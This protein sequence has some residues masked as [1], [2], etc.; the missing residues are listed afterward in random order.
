[1]NRAFPFLILL[2]CTG[3]A[4]KSEAT[5]ELRVLSNN[6]KHGH[7]MDGKVDISRAADLIN[8]LK[9]DLVVLQ[10][11]DNG[12]ERSGRQDQMAVLSD[13][14][15][16]HARFGPFMPYQ[17][18]HYGIGLMSRF[19][20]LESKN[21][22][23]PEGAEP[24]SALEARVQLPNAEELLLCS[25]HLYRS[26][27]E[28]LAQARA[29]VTLSE[30]LETPMILG[31]TSTRHPAPARMAV[32]RG[33]NETPVMH[34]TLTTLFL[35]TLLCSFSAIGQ[36]QSIH[37]PAEVPFPKGM[38]TGGDF[39]FRMCVRM[40]SPPDDLPTLAANKAWEEG[41]IKDYTTNNTYGV[42][43]ESG[44]QAGFA[45]SVL[46]DGAW[47]WNAGDGRRRIDHRPEARD[48]G[49]ADGRWH[50]L[51]FAIDREH[52][53]AHLYHDGRRVAVHDLQGVGSLA[54]KAAS[55]AVGSSNHRFE[56]GAVRLEPGVLPRSSFA[57]DFA[58]RFGEARRPARVAR[59]DGRPLRVLAWNIWHGGR[60]KGRDEG[61]Q[62][63]VDVIRGCK[64]DIVL[65]QET[66]G[67]GPRIS[68]RLGFD[69]FLRSANLSVMSRFPIVGVH[70]LG[71]GFRFG[72]VTIEL[73]PK[74]RV[75]AYSLWINYL[76]GVAKQ[77]AAGAS[78]EELVAADARTRGKEMD[79]ILR[80]LLPYLARS[81]NM[82]VVV[83]GDFNSGS[84]LDWTATTAHLPNHHGLVVP[85]PASR[86]MAKAGFVDA[87]R[88]ANPDP[89]KA[90][91]HTWSPEF[92]DSHQER[93]D[94]VY[95]RGAS[96]RV[97][98][99]S[100]LS[101][102]PCGWPSDHAAVLAILSLETKKR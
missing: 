40:K 99:A 59:W 63:V 9:P 6:I 33:T 91:G 86:S 45:I 66:Y 52:G 90:P 60:R 12:A 24:R 73:R 3:C 100:V 38:D 8:R 14:T 92:R 25:V 78:A 56:I 31:A 21:H 51:G 34:P 64:A 75:Q 71:T 43:R 27:E 48:Q 84:H 26:L 81:P 15:G 1:M 11:I 82:P 50:E 36:V 62:R 61:V 37:T 4:T 42:G 58:K 55:I 2:A 96:W 13:L 93:I 23:L 83:G 102:H 32:R 89:V 72:G 44:R 70:R 53:V 67:S 10:E 69:Y 47:T 98:K 57:S 80:V 29:L 85:W 17:G 76:P 94:Y 74:V 22:V 20:I 39:T 79:E 35:T 30:S 19:P 5:I 87:F 95:V 7:G 88:T 97:L 16:L 77:L 49:I 54:S 46:A 28:R 41:A 18:G 68:G 101:D 65:M